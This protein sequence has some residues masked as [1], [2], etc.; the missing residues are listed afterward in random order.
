MGL[1]HPALNTYSRKKPKKVKYKSAEAKRNAD[2]ADAL[3]EKMKKE[4]GLTDNIKLVPS[5][6]TYNPPK[7]TYRGCD[8]P[9]IPS[10][11][12]TGDA[13]L[14]KADKVYTGTLIKGIATMHKSNAVPIID[15]QQATD[16]ARMRR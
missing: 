2:R 10:Y 13:C 4:Y 3:W 7:P 8:D 6:K 12:F 11:N 14:K 9:K 15:E 5:K 1:V 16:I